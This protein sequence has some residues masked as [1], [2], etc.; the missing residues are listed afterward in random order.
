MLG[1]YVY[2]VYTSYGYSMSEIGTL[3]VVG[4]ISS[5]RLVSQHVTVSPGVQGSEI[6][7]V[8]FVP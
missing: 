7:A 2:A 3:Y 4:F 5:L 6:F 1:P 8:V